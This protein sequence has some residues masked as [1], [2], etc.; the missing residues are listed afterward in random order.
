MPRLNLWKKKSIQ[1]VK[2][3]HRRRRGANLFRKQWTLFG[4]YKRACITRADQLCQMRIE[5][6]DHSVLFL[7]PDRT[8]RQSSLSSNSSS[9]KWLFD[10]RLD[11]QEQGL[12]LVNI[13]QCRSTGPYKYLL[14]IYFVLFALNDQTSLELERTHSGAV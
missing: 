8:G 12:Y 6:L 5:K 7:G 1:F 11:N 3:H 14:Q 13:S 4:L 10:F 2:D 9:T